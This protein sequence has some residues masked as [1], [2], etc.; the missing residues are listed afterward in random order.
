MAWFVPAG[1][2][3]CA[4]SANTVTVLHGRDQVAMHP[5]RFGAAT[6]AALAADGAVVSGVVVAVAVFVDRV[7]RMRYDTWR[8]LDPSRRAG[9]RGVTAGGD[10]WRDSPPPLG[11]RGRT[12]TGEVCTHSAAQY[13]RGD[14][15]AVAE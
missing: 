15:D 11:L 5:P 12:S 8:H 14:G 13:R 10:Q 6:H 3:S 1:S 9:A 7:H 4:T 2:V